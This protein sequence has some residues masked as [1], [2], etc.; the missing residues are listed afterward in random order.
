M[1]PKSALKK[2]L[3]KLGA[4]ATR[5]H[6]SQ[7]AQTAAPPTYDQ[8][9]LR[10]IHNHDF[11]YDANFRRAYDRGSQAA[12]DY[13]WH[14]RVHIGLWAAQTAHF[15][16]G[17]FVECGVNRGFLSSAIMSYLHWNNQEK[18]FYLLDTFEGL[19]PR[20]VSEDDLQHGA[21]DKNLDAINSGFYVTN[22]ES[23][24]KNF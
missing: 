24:R 16:K 11:M 3:G 8:D 6:P 1:S 20:Y 22:I 5:Q 19:D 21:I 17:D 18:T 12:S 13:N 10:S 7:T 23:V 2:L 15:L 14:W 9:G 4:H